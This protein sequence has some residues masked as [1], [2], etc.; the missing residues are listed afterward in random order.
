ML[1]CGE[2][3]TRETVRSRS[4]RSHPG[5]SWQGQPTHCTTTH[6]TRSCCPPRPSPAN[7]HPSP[8]FN[9]PCDLPPKTAFTLP[10]PH[11]PL[12]PKTPLCPPNATHPPT[13]ARPNF[14]CPTPPTPLRPH[15]IHILPPR[16]PPAH[17]APTFPLMITLTMSGNRCSGRLSNS[18]AHPHPPPSPPTPRPPRPPSAHLSVDDDVDDEREQ[19][20]RQ[21]QYIE[22]RQ[23]AEGFGCGER[24]VL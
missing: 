16:P 5:R 8:S 2:R 18:P 15:P 6:P 12:C 4:H 22:Q 21:T 10:H 11:S 14:P 23:R 3:H 1:T 9:Q 20:Q 24:L 17:P 19:M 13:L 7:L